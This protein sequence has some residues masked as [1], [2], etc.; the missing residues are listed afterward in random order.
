MRQYHKLRWTRTLMTNA[1]KAF[2]SPSCASKHWM[3][4][5]SLDLKWSWGVVQFASWGMFIP[6]QLSLSH[7]F[8][9]NHHSVTFYFIKNRLQTMLWHHN[10]RVN[11]HQRWKQTRFRVCFHLWCELTST[12]NV[13]EYKFQGIH[14]L[15]RHKVGI[16]EAGVLEARIAHSAEKLL[17]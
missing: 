10:A 3:V 2:S 12:M 4:L 9:E 16:A 1:E 6:K 14:D 13:T 15:L 5:F 17:E 11:S 8:H 7:E